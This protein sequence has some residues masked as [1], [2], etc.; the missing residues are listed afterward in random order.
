MS[1]YILISSSY[2]NTSHIGLGTTL[3]TSFNFKYLFKV[4]VSKCSHILRYW[5]FRVPTYEFGG[6][7]FSPWQ[8]C[9]LKQ[10]VWTTWISI[11]RI[12]LFCSYR[13]LKVLQGTLLYI[14]AL[15]RLGS[16]WGFACMY[17]LVHVGVFLFRIKYTV[18]IESLKIS[19]FAPVQKIIMPSFH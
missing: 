3:V 10:Y 19:T 17:M 1:V 2:K 8:N 15:K 18:S 4:P 7:Q 11:T 16:Q 12:S 14:C 9:Q 6:I 13:E 5:E